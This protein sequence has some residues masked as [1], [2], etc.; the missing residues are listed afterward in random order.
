VKP[1]IIEH[2]TSI[3]LVSG[4]LI[5]LLLFAR[6]TRANPERGVDDQ[7]RELAA[8][9]FVNA[10][11][12]FDRALLTDVLDLYYPGQHGINAATAVAV[13]QYQ[14]KSLS[15]AMQ[16]SH[17]REHLD[18]AKIGQLSVMY[19]SFVLIYLLVLVVTYYGVQTIGAWRFVHKKRR[20]WSD[21]TAAGWKPRVQRI[22]AGTARVIGSFLL[23][24]P[25]YVIA[26]SIRSEFGTDTVPFMVLL[27]VIS[28]GLL[29]VYSNKFY[30]FLV[31]E[32]RKGYVET[33]LVKNLSASYEHAGEDGIPYGAILA[34]RKRFSGH[35]FNQIFRNARH[36]YLSS[37]KEQASFLIS[38]LII[39][40]MALN[41]HGHLNY[42]MLR[43]ILY[44]NFDIVIAIILGIFYTV[45]ATEIGVDVI[46]FRETKK[47]ENAN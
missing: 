11:Q 24:C 38:G 41:I 16:E 12:A 15:R 37:V 34:V 25:A 13:E 31:A 1:K 36:Q 20:A 35:V 14:Q 21:G 45:K 2:V 10:G 43:Q 9:S 23:F 40:E 33:A 39:I 3:L 32:S 4:V 47:Y 28:N 42:E 44:G 17:V 5:V 29:L 6:H 8:L 30:S 27:A 22:A 19:V 26:Y 18:A 46:V 7:V